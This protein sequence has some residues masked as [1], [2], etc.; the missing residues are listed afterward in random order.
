MRLL[1]FIAASAILALPVATEAQ[2]ANQNAGAGAGMATGAVAGAIVGGPVG[3][4]VGGVIG[5]IAG[6]TLSALEAAQV[7][8]Y[9]ATQNTPSVRVQ[10]RVAPGQTLSAQVPV[11]AIP[12]DIGVRTPY[13]YTVLN[14]QTVLVDPQTRQIVQV[15]R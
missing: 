5:A 15:I 14:E 12:P 8:Q 9:A 7:Q 13:G 11:Y 3:A 6:S 4:V 10:E 1:V 2:T